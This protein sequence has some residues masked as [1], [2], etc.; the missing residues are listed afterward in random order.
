[1][2]SRSNSISFYAGFLATT[3]EGDRRILAK[4]LD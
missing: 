1:M 4:E 2:G 3:E